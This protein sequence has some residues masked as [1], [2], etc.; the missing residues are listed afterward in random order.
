MTLDPLESKPSLVHV[1]SYSIQGFCAPT[2]AG[3]LWG[4]AFSGPSRPP[5]VNSNDP[6]SPR[7]C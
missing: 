4:T 3:P 7:L 6:Y 2:S 1:V 5:R